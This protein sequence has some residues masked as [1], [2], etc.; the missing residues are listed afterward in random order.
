MQKQITITND[1]DIIDYDLDNPDKYELTKKILDP[2]EYNWVENKDNNF[3]NTF[4]EWAEDNLTFDELHEI[5]MMNTLY[6]YPP[7]VEFSE[8]DRK[9]VCGTTTLLYDT[10]LEQWAVGMTGGGMDLTPHL[11]DTFIKLQKCIPENIANSMRL[12]YSAYVNKKQ[13][14]EN[15]QIIAKAFLIESKF[16]LYKIQELGLK[17]PKLDK[18]LTIFNK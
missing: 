17:E 9:L 7:F 8:S 10:E 4:E 2:E 1:F 3:Y 18:L 16:N 14:K 15:C 6:Y 5:P 13:H 12:N 11:A